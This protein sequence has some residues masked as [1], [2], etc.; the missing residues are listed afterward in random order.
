MEKSLDVFLSWQAVLLCLFT[1]GFTFGVR[2]VAEGMSASLS[3]NRYWNKAA[4]PVMPLILGPALAFV[5]GFPWPESL[6]DGAGAHALFG[7][8]C[9]MFSSQVYARYKDLIKPASETA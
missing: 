8:V 5:P 4:V 1:Y 9:A 3:T 7:F 2:S 6:G